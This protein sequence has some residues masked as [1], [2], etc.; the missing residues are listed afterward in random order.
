MLKREAPRAEALRMAPTQPSRADRWL[1][2]LFPPRFRPGPAEWRHGLV[3]DPALWRMK[4]AFQVDFLLRMGLASRHRLLDLGCGTLRG[5]LPI[6]ELLAAGNYA[7]VDV[8]PAMIEEAGRE[9]A[10]AGL[11]ERYPRLEVVPDLAALDLRAVY[12]FVWAFS[13]LPHLDDATLDDALAC[14]ARHLAPGGVAYA[15]VSLGEGR[16]ALDAEP[17]AVARPLDFYVERAA[18][19]G[20][21]ADPVARLRELGHVSC[22]P[23]ADAQL[24]LRFRPGA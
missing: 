23:V 11:A 4:R 14:A 24:V 3:G 18:A 19:A 1:G 2:R 5:G 20:L 7:G 6:V 22:D 15:N 12:D 21:V 17:A 16:V 9:V 13:L 10:E 8:S